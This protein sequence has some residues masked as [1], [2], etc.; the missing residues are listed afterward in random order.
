M[1]R[2]AIFSDIHSNLEALETAV[3]DAKARHVER[4]VVLGDSIGYG[5]NPNECFEWVLRNAAFSLMGNHEK[6]V[7]DLEIRERFAPLAREAILWT[8]EVM[9]MDFKKQTLNLPY[10][11][12]ENGLTFAHGSPAEPESFHYLLNFQEAEASFRCME[13]SIGFV[14][15]THIPCCFCESERSADH[16]EPG[17]LNLKKGERYILNPGSVGQPRDRDPR[18]AYGI[19]DSEAMTF[20]T[21]RLP[22]E[23]E[24]AAGKIRKAGLPRYLADRLL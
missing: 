2:Y 15:H 11:R 6:A 1:M 8:A 22:Y 4:W 13:G 12:I 3:A 14:G 19:F 23:N 24:K 9:A 7:L 16:L 5:A 21:V 10:M 20:E 18:L 17:I